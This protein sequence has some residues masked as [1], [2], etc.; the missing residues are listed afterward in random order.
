MRLPLARAPCR[1]PAARQV[2]G[3]AHAE[4]AHEQ[5]LP[6]DR[7][8]VDEAVVGAAGTAGAALLQAVGGRIVLQSPP[9]EPARNRAP[10][11]SHH[12]RTR[13]GRRAPPGPE[14]TSQRRLLAM[15][16]SLRGDRAA[17]VVP[18]QRLRN[19][20]PATGRLGQPF[21]AATRAP[22][23]PDQ[24]VRRHRVFGNRRSGSCC[25]A[26]GRARWRGLRSGALR[27]QPQAAVD[28]RSRRSRLRD[29]DECG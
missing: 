29:D 6:A 15:P 27:H 20:M 4:V 19:P 28:Q 13:P 1:W 17:L 12:R 22:R 8:D 2:A 11:R 24:L 18:R 16:F 21:E 14:G 7:L 25:R 5:V 3:E 10:R 23:R 9:A 26:P